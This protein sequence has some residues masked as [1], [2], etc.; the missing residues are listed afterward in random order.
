M[1]FQE[2]GAFDLT[3]ENLALM[4]KARPPIGRDGLPVELHHRGQDPTGP[5]DEYSSTT[6][7]RVAH[8]EAPSRIDRG[9]FA[10]ERA[11]YWRE[12]AR[13]LLGQG[14]DQQ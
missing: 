12:R 2:S 5:L 8:T 9:R 7:D 3:P 1:G 14:Q 10:G 4:E 6:H 11:R 13:Q